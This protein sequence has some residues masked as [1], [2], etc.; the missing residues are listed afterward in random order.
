MESLPL[1]P[2]LSRFLGYPR[3]AGLPEKQQRGLRSFWLD[4]LFASLATSFVDSFYTLYLLSLQATNAQI[5]LSQTLIQLSGAGFALPGATMADRTGRYQRFSLWTSFLSRAMWLVMLAA[6]FVL[7]PDPAIWLVIIGY[8][9]TAAFTTLGNSAWTALTANLVPHRLRGAYFASRTSIMQLV[10]LVTIPLAGWLI[11]TIGG[12]GGYQVNLLI[13]F[14]IGLISLHYFRQV[15]EYDAP[16]ARVRQKGDS[17]MAVLRQHPTF[18]RFTLAH[19]IMNFGVMIG[20]PFFQVYLVEEAGFDAATV[21][22]V[23]TMMVFAT[24]VSMWLFGRTH[25][26]LGMVRTMHFGLLTPLLPVMWLWIHE[27]WQGYVVNLIS[28]ITWG[29]YNLGAFNLL[30]ACTPDAYRSRYVAIHSTIVAVAA[31]IGPVLGGWI[32]D[33]SSFTVNFALSTLFRSAG[34]IFFLYLVREPAHTPQPSST[35]AP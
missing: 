35:E 9:G 34:L 4:G 5:G 24:M 3:V 11:T 31:A 6:P 19:A 27:P 28:G 15:P 22:L 32:L 26:R 25:D 23:S 1:P 7:A 14:L 18:L 10:R 16:P 17:M 20:S 8:V 29:A 30:L 2:R 21:G 12:T 33:Q 13:A